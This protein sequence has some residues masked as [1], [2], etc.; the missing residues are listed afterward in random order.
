MA[1]RNS[2]MNLS[3][4]A[5]VTSWGFQLISNPVSLNSQYSVFF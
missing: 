2:D 1:S 5:S 3:N 4:S